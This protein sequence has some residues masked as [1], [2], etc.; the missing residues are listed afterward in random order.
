MAVRK[1]FW[2]G[3]GWTAKSRR[4]LGA[5]VLDGS[6]RSAMGRGTGRLAPFREGE[7]ADKNRLGGLPALIVGS[8]GFRFVIRVVEP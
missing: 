7:S 4:Q 6:R 3:R 2:R 1:F 5:V 8:G